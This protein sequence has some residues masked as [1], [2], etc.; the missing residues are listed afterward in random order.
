MV[1]LPFLL[2]FPDG[3]LPSPRWRIVAWVAA[4]AGGVI[5]L[6]GWFRPHLA[7]TL[8]VAALFNPLRRRTQDFIDRRFYRGKYDVRKTL[9][10]FS[11]KLRDETDLAAL[12]DDLVI[13]VRRR[14]SRSRLAVV[15]PRDGSRGQ[16]ARLATVF[17]SEV[18]AY[19][20]M[21]SVTRVFPAELSGALRSGVT[22]RRA[23]ASSR[24]RPDRV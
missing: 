13:V 19:K 22:T 21:A 20:P 15:T 17:G 8:T 12:R 1:I 11:S 9:E 4:F 10:A 6:L 24:L 5:L 3:R 23:S 7:S 14:C 2:L 18:S 16:A